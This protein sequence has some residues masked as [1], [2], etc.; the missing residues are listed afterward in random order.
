MK[1]KV[2][3]LCLFHKGVKMKKVL[4]VA[5]MIAMFLAACSSPVTQIEK[6]EGISY[7]NTR[8]D[9]EKASEGKLIAAFPIDP[10]KRILMWL[11]DADKEN[12]LVALTRT[13][14]KTTMISLFDKEMKLLM[15][16]P[17]T[18][19]KGPGEVQWPACISIGNGGIYILDFQ[20]NGMEC[21]DYKCEYTDSILFSDLSFSVAFGGVSV[22]VA[23]DGTFYIGPVRMPLAVKLSPEG[24]LLGKVKSDAK[25]GREAMIKNLLIKD[26]DT[27][28]NLYFVFNGRKDLY[29]IRKYDKGLNPVWINRIEDGW[30][31]TLSSAPVVFP[32]GR[33]QMQGS[34]ATEGVC[35]VNGKVYVLRGTGGYAK[36]EW[37][38]ESIQEERKPIPGLKKGFVDVFDAEKGTFLERR[39]YPFLDTVMTYFLLTL[40]DGLY[41]Y[42]PY[43]TD[44][45][46]NL[47]EG[48]NTVYKTGW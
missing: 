35:A 8:I 12:L 19:G 15:D 31:E 40:E 47:R 39:S 16:K 38:G 10:E 20:K 21:F 26:I 29:E 25:D 33:F 6:K 45:E 37:D 24:N 22:D 7:I 36:Y 43:Q 13:A 23:G 1:Q 46:G 34:K 18:T 28:G 9:K 42:A 2:S 17:L 11:A 5:G 41:F 48:A 4:M 32:N 3:F 30:T 44:E 14:E 27:E